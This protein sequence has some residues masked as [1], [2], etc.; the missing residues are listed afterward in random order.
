MTQIIKTTDLFEC[1]PMFIQKK[2]HGEKIINEKV[3]NMISKCIS[4]LDINCSP[5]FVKIL[6]EDITDKYSHESIEDIAECLKKGRQGNYGTSYNKLTMMVIS[7]WMAKHLEE[8]AHAREKMLKEKF[9]TSKE[10][11]AVVDYEAYKIRI[12]SKIT[13]TAKPD[14]EVLADYIEKICIVFNI[15]LDELYSSSRKQEVVNGR[16][17]IQ[18]FQRNYLKWIN[19]QIKEHWEGSL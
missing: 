12:N 13:G 16:H 6:A 11:L 17:A 19:R 5:D 10:P 9:Q 14:R 3:I 2:H 8:K 18:N 7:E 4:Q 1:I 15:T